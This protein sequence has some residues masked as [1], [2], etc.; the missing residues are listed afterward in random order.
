MADEIE[1]LPLVSLWSYRAEQKPFSP[2]E[3]DHLIN[4]EECTALLGLCQTCTKL[5]QVERKL[6]GLKGQ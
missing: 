3:L 1:H 6:K 4:C 2:E 5:E